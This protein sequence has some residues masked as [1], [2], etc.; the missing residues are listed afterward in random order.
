MLYLNEEHLLGI[1]IPWHELIDQLEQSVRIMD[2]GRFVQ[3]LKPYLR[4]KDPKNRIIAMPAYVGGGIDRA[5]IKWIASF[6]DNIRRGKPRAHSVVILNDPDTG[7]PAAIINTSL[8]SVIR[9]ASLSGLMLK[10]YAMRRP[11]RG[12]NIGI[13]GLGPIGRY[14]LRMCVELFGDDIEGI[15]LYDLKGIDVNTLDSKLRSRV[16]VVKDWRL[17]YRNSDVF[18]TCTVSERRYVNSPPKPGSLLLHVSLRDYKPE[19]L[20][21]VDTV[22]VDDWSEVCRENTDIEMLHV[23]YGLS[24]EH[25]I[26]LEDVVC[27]DGLAGLRNDQVLLFCPMGMAV[28]DIATA[29]FYVKRA[30]ALEV[31]ILVP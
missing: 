19:A 30:E 17:V 7:E 23:E 10:H 13:I 11:L 5:G 3:P 8:L 1:G 6:P 24:E 22:V 28:F 9:T 16:T 27:R 20:E 31:G 4:Y 18:I 25:T 29:D 2:E 12:L 26:S 15:Y 14:H 21:N